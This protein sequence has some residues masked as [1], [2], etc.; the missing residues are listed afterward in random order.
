MSRTLIA[1]V[2]G[3]AGFLVY[4]VAIMILS[5]RI[6]SAHWAVQALFFLVAGVL[7]VIPARALMLW[8][9]RRS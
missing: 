4:V 5:D 8:A 9:A 3:L 7:W 2:A 6:M 1:T